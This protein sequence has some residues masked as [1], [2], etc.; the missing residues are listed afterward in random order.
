M[1]INNLIK[2]SFKTVVNL[3]VITLFLVVFLIISNFFTS[4]ILT[5]KT[6][7]VMSILMLCAFLMAAVFVSG[8][9]KVIK[10][11]INEDKTKNY[12]AIFLE[13]IGKNLLS[14]ILAIILY[15]VLFVGVVFLARF[16]AFKLF[17]GLDF[18][19]KEL[20]AST[21]NTQDFIENFNKLTLSQQSTIYGWY[22]TLIA[23]C[24]IFNFL[25]LFYF[26]SM[27]FMEDKNALIRPFLAL[28]SSI[29]FTFK[30]FFGTLGICILIH[31]AYFFIALLSTL[32]SNI[33]ISVLVLFSYI[34]FAAIT[35]MLLFNYYDKKTDCNNRADSIGQDETCDKISTQD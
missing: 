4:S 10:E 12:F 7:P 17:G 1:T 27:F 26:P 14:T 20:V 22:F 9:F 25:L 2:K 23:A 31:V 24:G 13:G 6:L 30:N 35:I 3:P 32:F 11:A 21:V 28:K 33:I 8:W 34:Y 16:L 19:T 5:A 18:L 29:V 15:F